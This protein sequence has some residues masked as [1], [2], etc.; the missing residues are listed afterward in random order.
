MVLPRAYL[1]KKLELFIVVS[2]FEEGLA[3]FRP[4]AD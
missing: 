3:R 4:T 2:F 1:F